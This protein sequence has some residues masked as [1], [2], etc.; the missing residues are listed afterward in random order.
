MAHFQIVFPRRPNKGFTLVELLVVIAIIGIL[1]ALLL[2][3]IQAAREAARRA[4]CQS[5]MHN[6]ALAVLNYESARKTLPEGM[7]FPTAKAGT[8]QKLD[9]FGP[10][11]I[12]N[13]LPYMEEQA[14][15]DKFDPRLF[16]PMDTVGTTF[17][18]VNDNPAIAV[19]QVARATQIPSL[20]CASDPFNRTLYQAGLSAAAIHGP[21]WARTNYAAN[22]RGRLYLRWHRQQLLQWPGFASLEG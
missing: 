10:N 22:R 2:P 1:V 9:S 12:I 17:Q 3:A 18:P 8:V 16:Q 6:V 20:L 21:G 13:V 14:L 5:N 4:Q 11:W 15:H 19:N 7:T